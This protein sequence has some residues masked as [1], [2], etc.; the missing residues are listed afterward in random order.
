MCRCGR[1]DIICGTDATN[2][3]DVIVPWGRGFAAFSYYATSTSLPK[4]S[5]T[6]VGYGFRSFLLQNLLRPIRQ[7]RYNVFCF[8]PS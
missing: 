3:T 2:S 6:E 4:I 8:F 1:C 7:W 5:E